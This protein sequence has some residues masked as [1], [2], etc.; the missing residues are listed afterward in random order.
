M[1]KYKNVS[2]NFWTIRFNQLID[3][4]KSWSEMEFCMLQFEFAMFNL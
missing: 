3:Q 4:N 1:D 2:L